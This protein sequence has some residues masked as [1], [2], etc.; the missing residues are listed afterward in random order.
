MDWFSFTLP[1][2]FCFFVFVF[3][4]IYDHSPLEQMC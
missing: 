1:V 3:P 2:L 4:G